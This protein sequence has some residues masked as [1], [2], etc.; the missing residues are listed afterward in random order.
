[1]RKLK[2]RGIKRGTYLSINHF[3][4]S[5]GEVNNRCPTLNMWG[6]VQCAEG[7]R[8]SIQD[9]QAL[10][11]YYFPIKRHYHTVE[12]II[13]KLK[14]YADRGMYCPSINRYTYRFR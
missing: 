11:N 3:Y 2:F 5:F 4:D 9:I 8:R 13:D 12:D 10:L 6:F 7:K 1:M 14:N